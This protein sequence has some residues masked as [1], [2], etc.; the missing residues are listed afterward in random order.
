MA[1]ERGGVVPGGESI[2]SALKWLSERRQEDPAVPR[3]KLIEEA[4]LRFDL[5]PLE[6]DFLARSWKE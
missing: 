1:N 3:M 6:A 2:R 5:T 4:A